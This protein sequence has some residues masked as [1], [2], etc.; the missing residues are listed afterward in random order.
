MQQATLSLEG[1]KNMTWKGWR[2]KPAGELA[3]IGTKA[4]PAAKA[5][6]GRQGRG[7][8][9]PQS[10]LLQSAQDLN[11]TSIGSPLTL[12]SN[13]QSPLDL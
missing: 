4:R 11:S 12:N 5:S 1:L 2:T 13:L 7:L 6:E 8:M 9:T 3:S 10:L